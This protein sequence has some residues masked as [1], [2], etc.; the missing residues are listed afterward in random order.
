MADEFVTLKDLAAEFGIHHSNVRPYLRKLG[1]KTQKR[2]APNS[3]NQLTGTLTQEEADF[4]RAKRRE[5]GYLGSMKPVEGDVGLF[6]VVQLVPELDSSRIKLGYAN[7]ISIRLT[8]H[9]TASPTARVLKTWPC[10][11]TW[12]STVMDA[13][14]ACDCR[15]IAN[16]VF[17]CS[18]IEALLD[19][20]DALIGLLP[21]P[22]FRPPLSE[23]SPHNT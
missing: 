1:I 4:V 13:L 17:E 12:E 10:K 16:E 11:R 8:Q 2:R 9:R 3:R 21:E 23:M 14:V 15:L 7:D 20:G 19:R 6:Y 5:A 22:S 18:D